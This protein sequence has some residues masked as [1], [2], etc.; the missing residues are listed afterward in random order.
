MSAPVLNGDSVVAAFWSE[1]LANV[2]DFAGFAAAG[3]IDP[4]AVPN[5]DF[6]TDSYL[7]LWQQ[8][9]ASQGVAAWNFRCVFGEYGSVDGNDDAITVENN[10]C[11]PTPSDQICIPANIK[12]FAS[13][14]SV[15][16]ASKSTLQVN[17]GTE[18]PQPFSEDSVNYRI[19]GVGPLNEDSLYSWATIYTPSSGNDYVYI[20]VR[21]I[22]TF[23]GSEQEV[24]AMNLVRNNGFYFEGEDDVSGAPPVIE[25]NWNNCN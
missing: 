8:A 17:L 22:D 19:F 20:L 6:D 5:A 21:D 25:T 13:R 10:S 15:E 23:K 12:G 14:S 4:P 18:E 2:T 1:G 24:E 11:F 16:G 9:Y 7:G 3:V